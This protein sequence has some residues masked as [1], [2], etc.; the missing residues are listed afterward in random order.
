MHIH[1]SYSINLAEMGSERD[2]IHAIAARRAAEVRRRL[3]A[4]ARTPA[5][6]DDEVDFVKAVTAVDSEFSV[7]AHSTM[8]IDRLLF[9]HVEQHAAVDQDHGSLFSALA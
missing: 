6:E 8:E 1:A 5:E 9:D 3:A 4:L 2:E 7:D